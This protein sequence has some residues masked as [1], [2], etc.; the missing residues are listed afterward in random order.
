MS[1]ERMVSANGLPQSLP[2]ERAVL[3]ACLLVDVIGPISGWL[4]P[5]HFA[6]EAHRKIYRAMVRMWGEGTAIDTLTLFEFMRDDESLA[7]AGGAAYLAGLTD[8][9][10]RGTN[11]EHYAGIVVEK[12]KA[13]RLLTLATEAASAVLSGSTAREVSEALSRGTEAVAA[14]GR[15]AMAT[16][17]LLLPAYKF[18]SQAPERIDWLVEGVIQRGANGVIAAA[19]RSG[20][21]WI[22]LDLAI[23]LAA[24]DSWLGFRVPRAANV[25]LLSREDPQA[26]TGWRM[27]HLMAGRG[28]EPGGYVGELWCNSRSQ[29]PTLLLDN[30]QDVAEITA[31]LKQHR[32]DLLILDVF[33]VLHAA[34]END[35]TEM[36]RVLAAVSRMSAELG[37]C[38][39]CLV[40]HFNKNTGDGTAAM[41]N[42]LRG[43]SAI[44]GWT[45][46]IIGLSYADEQAKIRRAEFELKAGQSPE[47]VNFRIASDA[48]WA[49][50]DVVDA[51]APEPAPAR[52]SAAAIVGGGTAW[53]RN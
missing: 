42:R 29:S 51:P 44:A 21:S 30:P 26:L 20:K 37:G 43:S 17:P 7:E 5:E 3:G 4:K 2:A 41:V 32:P 6:S 1:I 12:A 46:W 28:L 27:K 9:L 40:H 34:D 24:G 31:E 18:I 22:S 39:V 38:A 14:L 35:Q 19:P 33:N 25:A 15:P 52:R 10:P 49:R 8:G 45:Q 13:R 23:A 47:P 48:E 50:I 36:R 16:G 11:V 53:N